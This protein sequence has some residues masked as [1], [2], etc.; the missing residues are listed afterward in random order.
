VLAKLGKGTLPTGS[1][2]RTSTWECRVLRGK[3]SSAIRKIITEASMGVG[4]R[5]LRRRPNNRTINGRK[6]KKT[7]R[8]PARLLGKRYLKGDYLS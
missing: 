6:K 3:Y 4:D 7:L 8:N 2:I 1:H 5:T